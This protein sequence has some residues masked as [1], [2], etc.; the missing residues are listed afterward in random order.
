MNNFG[1]FSE[2]RNV[3]SSGKASVENLV[4]DCLIRAKENIGLNAFLEIFEEESIKKAKEID[5][6]I[7]Q[8]KSGRLAGLV[9]GIKDVFCYENHFLTGGSRFLSGFKSQFTATAISRLIDE[10]AIVI[11]RQNCDEFAM[12]SSNENS[13]FGPV[14]NF[15][16]KNRVPGGSSG[17]SAVAVQSG[18]CHVSIASDTGGSIR[19]PAAFC[20][21]VG[22]KPT[23][24][25]VSR[26]GLIAYGSSFDCVGPLTNSVED[27]GLLLEIM[28]GAD[29]FDST[30]SRKPIDNYS[31]FSENDRKYKIGF[32]RTAFNSEGIQQEIRTELQKAFSFFQ[33]QGHEV[34][35]MDLPLLDYVLPTYYV[36]TTSEASSNLSR[37]DG[38]R[39][40]ARAVDAK[41]LEEVFKL[42]RSE[43]FGP[44][45]QKRIMLGTFA[46]SA[47]YHEAYFTKA[48]KVRR[49][50][51]N[52]AKAL[53]NNFDFF[54]MPTTPTTAFN[55]GEK[56]KDP[57]SMYLADIFTV[58]A[59]LAGVPAINLPVGFDN[60]GLPIGIQVHSGFFEE[61]K[62]LSFSKSWMDF[63]NASK[64]NQL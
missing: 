15:I 17:G 61:R 58:W 45:V 7:G 33:S 28:S 5:E 14:K 23:Y 49:L 55:V 57:L 40:G 53:F 22:L 12:G 56:S 8:K 63:I 32:L 2:L 52:S 10:D 43:G 39:F 46:L 20:G 37:Y 41:D 11:G 13:G 34:V 1:S 29:G 31:L 38:I 27:A 48:Q 64:E 59:N 25:R 42:S 24:S 26:H 16:G 62:L 44:E 50:I 6:K 36:L 4:A 54:I 18:S 60:E 19:Q 47:D 3:I 35:A 51:Q 21:L 9:V 30:C